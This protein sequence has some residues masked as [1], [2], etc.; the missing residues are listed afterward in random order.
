MIMSLLTMFLLGILI[1]LGA[2]IINV[3]ASLLGI[4]GW[5]SYIDM[6]RAEGFLSATKNVG[7]LSILFM[8]IIYP[9]LLGLIAKYSID[10]L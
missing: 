4:I 9:L 3:V 7:I 8:Y 5:Y 6:I 10:Y 2:I 1:L